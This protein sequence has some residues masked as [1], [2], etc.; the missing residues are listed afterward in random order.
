MS[1]AWVFQGTRVPVATFFENIKDGA[2]IDDFLAWFPGVAREQVE[3]VLQFTIESLR[4]EVDRHDA[5]AVDVLNLA[6]KVYEGLTP[7]EI[8]EIERIA[9]D[10]SRWR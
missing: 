5:F 6:G 4:T 8:D 9:C 7:E 10:R 3:A 2:T 1:R